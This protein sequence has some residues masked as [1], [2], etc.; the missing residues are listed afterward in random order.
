LLAVLPAGQALL[1]TATGPP[2][3]AHPEVVVRVKDGTLRS[4]GD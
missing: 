4:F 3:G 1:T 2:P